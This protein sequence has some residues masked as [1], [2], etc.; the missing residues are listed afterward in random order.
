MTFN[1][2]FW[3]L[4]FGPILTQIYSFAVAEVSWN[5]VTLSDEEI[6]AVEAYIA[7]HPFS[8][9]LDIKSDGQ[10][11]IAYGDKASY[12]QFP[13]I[14]SVQ[15][16]FQGTYSHICGGVLIDR[17]LVLTAAHCLYANDQLSVPQ[18]V[19]LGV[20]SIYGQSNAKEKF[21][22]VEAI[23][24]RGYD[25]NEWNT[26]AAKYD[27][28]ILRINGL[29]SQP[30]APLATQDP[31]FGSSITAAGWGADHNYVYTSQSPTD[32]MYATAR[33][34]TGRSPCPGVAAGVICT[35]GERKGY[36]V[37][38]T[39]QGDSG[40]PHMLTG[41]STVIGV[42]SFGP[43]KVEQCGTNT[44]VGITS[45]AYFYNAF[46]KPT[47]EKYGSGG[48][49]GV[50]PPGG[51]TTPGTNP[52]PWGSG[53]TGGDWEDYSD[54]ND[55]DDTWGF[56]SRNTPSGGYSAEA[57]GSSATVE[58]V[59][60]CTPEVGIQYKKR[61]EVKSQTGKTVKIESTK[62]CAKACSDIQGCNAFNFK[63]RAQECTMF[64][65]EGTDVVRIV[66]DPAYN[67]GRL[68]CGEEQE[69]KRRLMRKFLK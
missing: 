37:T 46:I 52:D 1:A 34:N 59:V 63:G 35:A 20:T 30:V 15:Y 4:L 48:G 67:T 55:Y 45:T 51:G 49:S 22:V 6:K 61:L 16:N 62:A 32:L 21:S 40:G 56:W 5:N 29:S 68:F 65:L 27:I 36:G 12:G 17:N 39:C 8:S 26:A 54:Y 53:D 66:D 64:S 42:T 33:V 28:A 7:E 31:S 69:N 41:T 2:S 23:Y 24:P 43:G 18:L 13:S 58:G 44:Y 3:Y 25:H 47:L 10:S 50:A 38:S 9:D 60:D 57:P 11:R 19:L 14:A